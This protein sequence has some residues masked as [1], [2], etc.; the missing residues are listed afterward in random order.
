M[1][2]LFLE[3]AATALITHSCL[4][5]A[6]EIVVSIYDIFDNNNFTKYFVG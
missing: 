1:L 5:V 6:L 2:A 4:S 3:P